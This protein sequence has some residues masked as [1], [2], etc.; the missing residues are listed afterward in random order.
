MRR[1]CAATLTAIFNLYVLVM[2][3]VV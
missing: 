1:Y 2:L 3:N